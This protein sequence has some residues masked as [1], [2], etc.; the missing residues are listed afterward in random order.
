MIKKMEKSKVNLSP[1]NVIGFKIIYYFKTY[2]IAFDRIRSNSKILNGYIGN[3]LILFNIFDRPNIFKTMA[4]AY[5]TFDYAKIKM[6]EVT[7]L[8]GY[9]QSTFGNSTILMDPPFALS[10]SIIPSSYRGGI[11]MEYTLSSIDKNAI[12]LLSNEK[13]DISWKIKD[14]SLI[15]CICKEAVYNFKHSFRYVISV[16]EEKGHMKPFKYFSRIVEINYINIGKNNERMIISVIMD[17]PRDFSDDF[18]GRVGNKLNRDIEVIIPLMETD[19]CCMKAGLIIH[20]IEF[21]PNYYY[22]YH[23][24]FVGN[25]SCE[26]SQK[27]TDLS[28]KDI[29]KSIM[30][31]YPYATGVYD[32]MNEIV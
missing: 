27:L 23:N 10:Y 1:R 28:R 17:L 3:F 7:D 18:A 30:E 12:S 21:Y 8:D 22:N 9:K 15:D 31:K 16:M 14:G 20:N 25:V 29:R 32:S 6:I 4:C 5:A 13:Y 24:V 2:N 26:E 11:I 19:V